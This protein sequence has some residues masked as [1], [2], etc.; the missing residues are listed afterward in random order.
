M[1]FCAGQ[2]V[3]SLLL[4]QRP[5][6]R[7]LLFIKGKVKKVQVGGHS[8]R[9]GALHNQRDRGV[10]AVQLPAKGH[11]GGGFPVPLSNGRQLPVSQQ[12]SSVPSSQGS[13][14]LH[15]H[16]TVGHKVTQLFIAEV[17]MRF[18]LS[19]NKGKNRRF[20]KQSK[21]SKLWPVVSCT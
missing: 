13:V 20:Q 5:H 1:R 8:L 4:G 7:H 10:A 3:D 14:R 11:L 15:Q 18:D 16:L 6:R 17:G 2:C 9:A 21:Q 19:N 12:A